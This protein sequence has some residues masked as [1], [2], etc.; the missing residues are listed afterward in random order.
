[1][2]NKRD[3][4]QLL[5]ERDILTGNLSKF[6]AKL[7]YKE[8][9]RSTIGRIKRGERVSGRKLD[10]LWN[11]ISRNFGISDE[12]LLAIAD[13]VKRVEA[14]PPKSRK[15]EIFKAIITANEL[16]NTSP[17]VVEIISEM[18]RKEEQEPD[19]FYSILAYIYIKLKHI[20]PYTIKGHRELKKELVTLNDTLFSLCQ[21]INAQQYT[22]D[23]IANII[24]KKDITTLELIQELA[25]IIR[26]HRDPGYIKHINNRTIDCLNIKDGSFWIKE[27]EA[28]HKGCEL[29]YFKVNETIYKEIGAYIFVKLKAESEHTDSFK[30]MDECSKFSFSMNNSILKMH[31]LSNGYVDEID[32]Y[33]LDDKR[34]LLHFVFSKNKEYNDFGLPFTLEM[35]GATNHQPRMKELIKIT[36]RIKTEILES[37]I[38]EAVNSNPT[39]NFDILCSDKWI[40]NVQ[41]DFRNVI[42]TSGSI[43]NITEQYRID[44][45]N[46]KYLFLKD[47][48]ATV[49]EGACFARRKPASDHSGQATKN[50]QSHKEDGDICIYWGEFG[51]YI[52]LYEFDKVV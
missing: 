30:L 2:N 17:E 15:E 19:I 51:K 38:Q 4:L 8:K 29:W 28:F 12:T 37:Y 18:K 46:T 3:I 34:G 13:C 39:S 26:I 35:I 14:Y 40:E 21:T 45:N 9:S 44:R 47:L 49:S 11:N 1:M 31:D 5:F 10:T 24:K 16:D 32:S 33:A 6:V 25:I 52:P 48:T 41:I 43:E 7:G 50:C 22:K 42:I 20:H 23:A 27:G 36:D